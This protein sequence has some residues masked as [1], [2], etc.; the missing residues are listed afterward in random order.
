MAEG[1][2]GALDERLLLALR[3]PGVPSDPIGPRWFEESMRDITALGGFTI[4]TLLT[5]TAVIALLRFARRREAAVLA[6]VVIGTQLSS[7]GLKLLYGR[8]RP[9]LVPHGSIVYSNSFP[10]GHSALSAVTY[11]MLAVL[12][13]GLARRRTSKTMIYTLAILV[14]IGVGLSRIYLG[15][16]WPTDVLAGWSLGAAWT[17]LGWTILGLQPSA[18]N[19]DALA[20]TSSQ[21]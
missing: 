18:S 3:T 19:A 5:L 21:A 6:V 17:L 1:E 7:E 11:L 16:H 20:P 13:A 14:I 8:P 4:L 10:S 12:L 2:T 15:V 9:S